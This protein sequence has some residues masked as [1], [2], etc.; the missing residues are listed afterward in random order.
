MGMYGG[1]SFGGVIL[2]AIVLAVF[3][4]PI[5]RILRRAGFSRAWCLLFLVPFGN[6]VGLWVFAYTR[7]PGV[8]EKRAEVPEFH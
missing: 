1:M 2:A 7:W 4:I 8:E 6:I 3:L 5:A